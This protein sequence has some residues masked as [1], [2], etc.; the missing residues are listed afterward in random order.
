MFS[1]FSKIYLARYLANKD[2]QIDVYSKLPFSSNTINF[3]LWHY[4]LQA[5]L[6]ELWE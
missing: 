3:N 1:A 5:S 6:R 2:S 4:F